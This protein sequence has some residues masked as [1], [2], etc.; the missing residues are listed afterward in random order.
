MFRF[1]IL[2]TVLGV[3]FSSFAQ[4]SFAPQVSTNFDT[5]IFKKNNDEKKEKTTKVLA[6]SIYR[7]Y[8]KCLHDAGN[9]D[10]A[11]QKCK[12]RISNFEVITQK[13]F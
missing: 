8:E 13:I 4:A 11:V 6:K 3:S 10:A 12:E 5:S 1:R 2:V 7:V 9:N